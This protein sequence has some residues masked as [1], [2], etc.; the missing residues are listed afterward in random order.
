MK[1]AIRT[2]IV[3]AA[4][5]A[6]ASAQV[7][8]GGEFRVNTYSTSSQSDSAVA[9]DGDGNFVVVW[10]AP[11]SP[12]S[13]GVFGRRFDASGASLG[14]EFLVNTYTSET[15]FLPAVA[16]AR[17]GTFVVAWTT[18]DPSGTN[19]GIFGQR[20]DGAGL[21]LGSEFQ[22]NTYTSG[23]RRQPSVAMGP[24]GRFVIVWQSNGQDGSFNGV[25][26]QR[27]GSSGTPEGGE[28]RVNTFTTF[29]Q[30]YASVTMTPNGGFV[31]VWMSGQDGYGTGIVGQR[32][33]PLGAPLGGEFLVNTYTTYSQ[34]IP[35]IASDSDG[36]FLVVWDSHQDGSIGG[37][38]GQRYDGAGA[39][40]GGEFRVN[41]Y[42][43]NA[44]FAIN[45]GAAADA[46]GN[47]VVTWYS[48]QQDGSQW[49]IF[50]Q[51]FTSSGALRG[52]EFRI[53]TYTTGIQ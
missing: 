10:I 23:D 52:P 32:Y 27:F 30:S 29:D 44:Q 1:G 41:T 38:Y 16:R 24:G 11:D 51:R 26:G 47:F 19:G 33:D 28:F 43:T 13:V 37:V 7:P 14:A 48:Y 31:V 5:A 18:F 25:F 49:G 46:N 6:A 40:R 2:A 15:Q 8:A 39:P 22:V 50:G 12:G 53:N 3:F 36:N 21:P 9:A 42:T 45:T 34:E 20:F 4:F 35:S 17:N